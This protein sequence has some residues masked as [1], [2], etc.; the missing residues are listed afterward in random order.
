MYSILYTTY[1]SAVFEIRYLIL[2]YLGMLICAGKWLDQLDGKLILKWVGFAGLFGCL[3]IVSVTSFRT[4]RN[5][6]IDIDVM[7]EIKDNVEQ[8]D[9]PVVYVIGDEILCRNMRAFD[10][11]K[12]YKCFQVTDTGLSQIRHWG[13]YTYYDLYSECPGKVILVITDEMY[14]VIPSEIQDQLRVFLDMEG[15]SIYYLE[16][17]LL[18]IK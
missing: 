16:E 4:Y 6:R 1:G 8:I 11:D 18:G 17:N 5:T 14:P 12:V 2:P 9:S 10:T 13:D 15:M 7:Q 3:V